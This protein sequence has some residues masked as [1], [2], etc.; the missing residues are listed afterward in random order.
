MDDPPE[1]LRPSVWRGYGWSAGFGSLLRVSLL[2]VAVAA[3][4]G[5]SE[6]D[7]VPSG[8]DGGQGGQLVC[9]GSLLSCDGECVDP[10]NDW[11]HCGEC[12]KACAG[13]ELCVERSCRDGS[14]GGGGVGG[15]AGSSDS[16]PGGESGTGEGGNGVSGTSGGDESGAGATNPEGG[17][18]SG[19]SSGAA[20]DSGVMVTR[21]PC[22][23]FAEAGAPCAAAYSTVRRL[24]SSYTGPLYQVRSESSA[25]NTGTGGVLHDIGVTATGFADASAQDALCSGTV[26]TVSLLYDQS[27][28]GNH[29]TVAPAGLAVA[30][31]FADE[32]DFE[33]IA[34]S[35]PLVV[36]GHPVYSLHMQPRQGYRLTREGTAVPRKRAPQGLYLLADGTRQATLCCW[37]FGNVGPDPRSFVEPNALHFGTGFWGRGAGDGPW[38]LAD[39][40]HGLWA[41][42]SSPDDPGWG[43]ADHPSPPNPN[44]PALAVPFAVGFLKTNEAEWTLRM[45][46]VA[47]DDD[48]TTAFRGA[49]PKQP[50]N[51][52]GVVLGVGYD[53]ANNSWGTF[54]EG[55]IVAGYP[56]DATELAV[57]RNIQ[58][59]GYSPDFAVSRRSNSVQR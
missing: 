14:A 4:C 35:G 12:N 11:A 30:G 55:A 49:L 23:V 17:A 54:Y 26:C 37:T 56:D 6:K 8:R 43:G 5:R 13:D 34:D 25:E 1:R 59:A 9:S 29:L 51:G 15:S 48:L 19:A 31:D 16:T 21:G 2:L 52:G 39:F 22:D 7:A 27:G 46:D 57:M 18:G 36:G 20:G 33:S 40:G 41:G 58:A 47:A 53:N 44:N 38:F 24:S 3:G 45:A 28:N 50:Y 10:S 42:G 32:D